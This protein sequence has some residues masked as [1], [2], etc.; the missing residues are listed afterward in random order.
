MKGGV[1]HRLPRISVERNLPTPGSLATPS[2]RPEEDTED[3]IDRLVAGTRNE[4]MEDPGPIEER[5][6]TAQMILDHIRRNDLEIVVLVEGTE[7]VTS[8]KLQA[9]FS[10]AADDIIANF[11]FSPC[12]RDD[13]NGGAL[14]DF[15]KFQQ[16]VPLDERS[17]GQESIF[18]Q[19][20]L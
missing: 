20:V 7:S 1:I 3:S 15:E 11:A 2:S 13:G 4:I 10:Y 6:I 16:V 9:R 17:S 14:I 19:S 12:V 8:N 18:L 5:V